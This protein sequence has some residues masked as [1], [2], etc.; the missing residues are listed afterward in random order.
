MKVK[1]RV[2]EREKADIERGK[3]ERQSNGKEKILI[4]IWYLDEKEG[5]GFPDRRSYAPLRNRI[6]DEKEK[7]RK[8]LRAPA[9]YCT[10]TKPNTT[11]TE[12][13]SV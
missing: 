1:E 6:V 8:I 2:K 12:W 13:M 5:S 4:P 3:N 9:S 7:R 11:A 10:W